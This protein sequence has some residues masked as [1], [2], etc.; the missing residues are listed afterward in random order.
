MKTD[1]MRRVFAALALG[2]T[3]AATAIPIAGADAGWY[4]ARRAGWGE[5]P[6]WAVAGTG[7]FVGAAGG[8]WAGAR[9]GAMVGMYG[10]PIGGSSAAQPER[11]SDHSDRV[12]SWAARVSP[13]CP[14]PLEIGSSCKELRC[15]T[16]RWQRP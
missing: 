7:G 8:A 13:N 15:S 9:V 10:G 2:A 16:R 3:L 4:L 12:L 1:N 5:G 6:E 11:A 14:R